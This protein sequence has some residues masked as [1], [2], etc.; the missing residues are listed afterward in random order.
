LEANKNAIK[1]AHRYR[2]CGNVIRCNGDVA[3]VFVGWLSGLQLTIAGIC[4]I[5]S[6]A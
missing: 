3:Q 2:Y 1:G 4:P 6:A 5:G